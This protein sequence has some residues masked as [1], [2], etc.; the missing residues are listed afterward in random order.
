MSKSDGVP[1]GQA[2]E[3]VRA[4]ESGEILENEELLGRLVCW[5]FYWYQGVPFGV[6]EACQEVKKWTREIT[7][8]VR[9]YPQ[10]IHNATIALPGAIKNNPKV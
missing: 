3:I 8:S 7:E 5:C 9:S 4:I 2:Q 6:Q 10:F 1:M